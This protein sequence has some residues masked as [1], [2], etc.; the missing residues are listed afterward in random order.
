VSAGPGPARGSLRSA[1]DQEASDRT[2]SDTASALRRESPVPAAG[3]ESADPLKD[4]PAARAFPV[5]VSLSA[6]RRETQPFPLPPIPFSIACTSCC[7]L[8]VAARF[9]V[10]SVFSVS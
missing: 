3:A 10:L 7:S 9:A 4:E 5:P 6:Y 1:A 2:G 8:W